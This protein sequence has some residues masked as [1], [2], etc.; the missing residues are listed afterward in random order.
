MK[1][2][3][4]LLAL[5]IATLLVCAI[6]PNTGWSQED[7][8]A[9]EVV[10]PVLEALETEAGDG[11]AGVVAAA[12]T[13]VA[14]TAADMNAEVSEAAGVL[15]KPEPVWFGSVQL[16]EIV[17]SIIALV[18]TMAKAKM[19]L[20]ADWQQRVVGFVEAGAQHTYDEFIRG[21]K[22]AAPDGKLTTEQIN[23]ARGKAWEAA[24]VFAAEQGIDLAKQVT[25]E[26]IPVLFSKVVAGLKNKK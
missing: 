22:K 26:Q 9:V 3:R 12:E 13:T 1:L 18:W 5:M 25:T 2:V 20:D 16:W 10:A 14:T 4:S 11:S 21:A 19:K 8:P 15:E 24:K 17:G 23:E 6:T 7:P